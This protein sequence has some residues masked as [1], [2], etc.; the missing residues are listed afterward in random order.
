MRNFL[1]WHTFIEKLSSRA[2]VANRRC[3]SFLPVGLK[4]DNAEPEGIINP[5]SL[6]SYQVLHK[7][8]PVRRT[9]LQQTMKSIRLPAEF[10]EF[11]QTPLVFPNE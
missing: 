7:S 10:L 6:D 3:Y 2:I 8:T 9:D 4:K 5:Y 1:R 11:I